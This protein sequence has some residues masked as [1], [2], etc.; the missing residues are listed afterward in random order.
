MVCAGSD[1]DKSYLVLVAILLGWYVGCQSQISFLFLIQFKL[2]RVC[3]ISVRL[4]PITLMQ[5]NSDKFMTIKVGPLFNFKCT[6]LTLRILY[7]VSSLLNHLGA[8]I[9]ASKNIF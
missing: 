8:C 5:F 4:S 3:C 2:C 6:E 7:T 9:K 1:R